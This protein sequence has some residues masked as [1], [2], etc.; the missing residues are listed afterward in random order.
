MRKSLTLCLGVTVDSAGLLLLNRRGCSGG[1]LSGSG[2][3]V[4]SAKEHV[5]KAMTDGGADSYGSCGCSHLTE[6]ARLGRL[7]GSGSSGSGRGRWGRGMGVAGRRS[8]GGGRTAGL[9]RGSA[10]GGGRARGAGRALWT[11]VSRRGNGAQQGLTG[12][13]CVSWSVFN[14]PFFGK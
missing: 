5:G 13:M 3:L 4:A 10:G 12:M 7:G 9:G 2:S 1:L 8:G 14:S 11:G 6:H